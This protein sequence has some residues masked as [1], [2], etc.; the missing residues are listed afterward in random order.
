MREAQFPTS[1]SR[2][3]A[4]GNRLEHTMKWI[5]GRHR[6][7]LKDQKKGETAVKEIKRDAME[8]VGFSDKPRRNSKIF[9]RR[10]WCEEGMPRL[11]GVT[12]HRG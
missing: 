4:L 3:Q 7:D 8:E 6:R 2:R 1:A 12:F 9:N 11:E 10:R 5:D